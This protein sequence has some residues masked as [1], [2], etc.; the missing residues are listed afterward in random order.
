MQITFLI[1]EPMT[2][3]CFAP[4]DLARLA[5][6]RVVLSHR[7][8][9]EDLADFWAD[10][11]GET[12]VLITGWRTP[13]I[14]ETMLDQA[15]R[16]KALI[17]AAGSVRHLLPESTWQRSDLRIASAREALAVGVAETTLG[18]MIAGLKG[19]FPSQSLTSGGGWALPS[20]HLPG[21][22]I[23]EL[24]QSTIGIIGLSQSGRHVRRLLQS[25]EVKVLAYDPL[26]SPEEARELDVELV[27]LDELM[28]R[29]DIAS[30]HA[31]ALPETYRLLGARQ[32]ALMPDGAIFINTARGNI[33]DEEALAAELRTGRIWAFLDI[34]DPEPPQIDHPF[35]SLPNV[36]L[37]PHIAGAV[38]NGCLRIGRSTV[39][40][41]L[42]LASGR[43]MHG[44]INPSLAGT[45]A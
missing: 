20:G 11:A 28:R 44:E 38:G 2:R 39:N 27:S 32:F 19:F 26:V 6:H 36:V 5:P 9:A 18:M 15:P 14:T 31:P 41:V 34:T 25:F 40:Q 24:Y 23:R 43:A 29:S 1:T 8:Q 30:L 7:T 37:T 4:E 17:H 12:D 16:L 22:Q 21:F 10:H 13:T 33:V 45:L 42:E 3:L 35:R